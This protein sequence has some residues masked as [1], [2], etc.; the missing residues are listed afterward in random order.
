MV[1]RLRIHDAY[2]GTG[3]GLA[4]VKRIIGWHGGRIRLESTPD[5]G[6]TVM[7]TLSAARI[8]HS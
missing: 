5:K 8:D 3:E 6:S 2:E 1:R 7:D 4:I